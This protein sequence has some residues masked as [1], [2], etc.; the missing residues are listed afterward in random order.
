MAGMALT[1]SK[2]GG[3]PR[4]KITYEDAIKP[5]LEK[6][7]AIIDKG[8]SQQMMRNELDALKKDLEDQKKQKTPTDNKL[9]IIG[10]SIAG[11][12]ILGY[13]GYKAFVASKKGDI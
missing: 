8:T 13:F 2:L 9:A 12:S 10:A 7:K 5:K 3:Q 6:E 11:V 4:P 1:C